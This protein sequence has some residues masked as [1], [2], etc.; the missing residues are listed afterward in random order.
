MKE[1][2]LRI[3]TIKL[4]GGKN[5]KRY[6]IR[7]GEPIVVIN[8]DVAKK[9]VKQI[10]EGSMKKLKTKLKIDDA[11]FYAPYV[12]LFVDNAKELKRIWEQIMKDVR[13]QE[14]FEYVED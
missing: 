2:A 8:P 1:I 3:K 9:L 5:T 11:Y 7:Y 10:K 14:I 12:P 13:R 4:K 6:P